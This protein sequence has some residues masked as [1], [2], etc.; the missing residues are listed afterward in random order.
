MWYVVLNRREQTDCIVRYK[1]PERLPP[2]EQIAITQK[3]GIFCLCSHVLFIIRLSLILPNKNHFPKIRIV[4]QT[5]VCNTSIIYLHTYLCTYL[6][7]YSMEQNPSWEANRFSA[8]Q[9]TP[10]ILW[11]PTAH[12]RSHKCPP[13]DPILSQLDPVHTPTSHFLKIHLNIILPST[14][15]QA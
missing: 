13:P 12:Y 15:I 5:T 10:R 3:R 2:S 4:F 11:N 6:L 1:N 14:P 7:I 9:E 8:S